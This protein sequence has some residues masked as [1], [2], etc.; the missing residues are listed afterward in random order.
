MQMT[1]NWKLTTISA[2]A[3]RNHL[4]KTWLKLTRALSATGLKLFQGA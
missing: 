3:Y 2:R 4:T 1:S